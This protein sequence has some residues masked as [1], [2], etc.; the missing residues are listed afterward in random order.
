MKKAAFLMMAAGLAGNGIFAEVT[1]GGIVDTAVVPYQ[2]VHKAETVSNE[3]FDETPDLMGAGA[4]RDGTGNGARARLDVRGE[5]GG[6]AGFRFRIEASTESLSSAETAS[7]PLTI[8]DYLQVWWK[9]LPFLRVD[10]GRF[11]DTRMRGKIGDDSTFA[12]WTVAMYAGDEIFSRFSTHWTGEAGLMLSAGGK[13]AELPVVPGLHLAALLYGLEPFTQDGQGNVWSALYGEHKGYVSTV[14]SA[15]E[16]FQNVQAAAA[17]EVPLP[18]GTGDNLHIRAQYFGARPGVAFQR[19]T[20]EYVSLS[21]NLTKTYDFYTFSLTASKVE[22]AVGAELFGSSLTIDAGAKIPLAFKNWTR[23]RENI[24]TAEN[25]LTCPTDWAVYSAYKNGFVW[26][27]PYQ[28]SFAARYDYKNWGISVPVRVD[29]RFGGQIRGSVNE[30]NMGHE[31]NVHFWPSYDFGIAKVGID[32]GFET[33][34]ES[35]DKDGN[36]IGAGTPRAQDGGMRIGFGLWIEKEVF[37]KCVVKGGAAYRLG[38][39]VNGAP[40]AAVLTVPLF[41]EFQF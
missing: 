28:V 27:A 17:Y 31:I 26:Q 35:T 30:Y 12:S 5:G 37:E 3:N 41:A 7:S 22:A 33:I 9:P 16:V 34:G 40:E 6:I 11:H 19:L 8:E 32:A 29:A 10:A 25:E 13:G 18:T 39:K 1:V 23:V 24:Y 21:N 14:T 15:R 36:L 2:W 20:D 38:G 4:G